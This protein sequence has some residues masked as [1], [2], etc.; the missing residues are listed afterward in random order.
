MNT[1]VQWLSAGDAAALDIDEALKVETAAGPVAVYRLD[2]GY[3]AT[4][5]TCTHAVASLAEGFVE[6]GMIECP[7]HAARFCIR[8]GR[9]RSLP[10]SV[11]LATYPVKLKDGKIWIGLATAEAVS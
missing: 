4:Q 9:A 2:D 3:Y 6:D 8:S 10:A 5:D 1:T 7:L 11:A